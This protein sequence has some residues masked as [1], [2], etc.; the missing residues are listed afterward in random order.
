MTV[1][2]PHVGAYFAGGAET[3]GAAATAPIPP[4]RPP[5]RTATRPSQ[6]ISTTRSPTS[7]APKHQVVA[8][9]TDG[10][11]I[12][13]AGTESRGRP[14]SATS[15]SACRFQRPPR[16]RPS[17]VPRRVLPEHLQH[18]SD[19]PRSPSHPQQN[20]GYPSNTP[21]IIP[22]GIT[23]IVP[24][25]NSALAFVTYN[26]SSGI[27]PEY[28]PYHPGT[29]VPLQLGN[30]ATTATAPLAGVFSTD[31]LNFYAGASDGQVHLISIN[32]TTATETGVLK[33]EPGG[34]R[35]PAAAG[36]SGQPHRPASQE[37]AV[38]ALSSREAR[39]PPRPL[40]SLDTGVRQL[41]GV[42]FS[43]L[44]GPAPGCFSCLDRTY[45]GPPISFTF[46]ED[47]AQETRGEGVT[48]P[49]FDSTSHRAAR[50][51][52]HPAPHSET[53]PLGRRIPPGNFQRLIDHDCGRCSDTQASPPR[54]PQ[55]VAIH[56]SHALDPPVLRVRLDQPIDLS[57]RAVA[58]R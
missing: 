44:P 22:Q 24:A 46:F 38:L 20:P 33:P 36:R 29:I 1:T 48:A 13:G 14:S 32:G 18:L 16:C 34:P 26:G 57:S 23:G 25:S 15:R 6:Q 28:I 21:G 52:S 17:D 50:V 10:N 40:A 2:V 5:P 30:G 27:L 43:S 3:P 39:S 4:S 8:A 47:F 54:P 31:N 51:Q 41:K 56:H 35:C 49:K 45:R 12:L 9:T 37:D 55:Q 7:A 58:T 19:C 42:E 11:H 53:G